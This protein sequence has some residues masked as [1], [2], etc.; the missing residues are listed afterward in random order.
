MAGRPPFNEFD[1]ETEDIESYLE[2]L[3]E[4]FTAYDINDDEDNAAKQSNVMP[5]DLSKNKLQKLSSGVFQINGILSYLKNV[6]ERYKQ[7]VRE[8]QLNESQDSHE[9]RNR[10]LKPLTAP[11]FNGDKRKFEDV[12][13]LLTS[14][15]GKLTE[16][17][18]L[19]I[20]RLWQCLTGNALEAMRG[21][22]VT[23]HEYEEAKDVLKMT[24]GGLELSAKVSESEDSDFTE[25]TKKNDRTGP[26]G[27][28]K[29]KQKDVLLTQIKR[30]KR[31][32]KA[33]VTKL[34]HEIRDIKSVIEQLWAALED[35][36]EMLEE[37]TALYVEVEEKAKKKEAFEESVMIEREVKRTI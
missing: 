27:V 34:R 36:K 16:P 15:V 8:D 6:A 4:Y 13:A 7:S 22:V 18:H 23:A 31:T 9:D 2:R 33:K 17:V 29:Q 21:L 30:R 11:T 19:N 35:E 25:V 24:C 26:S 1:A 10:Y 20:A 37:M 12:W 5:R 3:Q 14:L 28:G 32:A